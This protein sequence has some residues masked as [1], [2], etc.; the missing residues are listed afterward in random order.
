MTAAPGHR[1]TM[2]V[3]H[4]HPDDETYETGGVMARYASEGVRVV[5]VVATRG[6]VGRIA[7]H[8][9]D[10]ADNRT[11]LGALREQELR[12]ACAALAPGA[13][14]EV[15]LLGYRDSGIAGDPQND[16]PRSFWRADPNEAVVR[17]LEIMRR[18][19]PDVVVS[20]NAY[21]TDGHPDH[22][23][24]AAIAKA[25]Y[26]QAIT[27][28]PAQGP[29][30][31]YEFVAGV[32]NRR[33][34]LVRLLRRGRVREIAAVTAGYVG[35]WRPGTE[36]ERRR[37]ARASGPTTTRVDVTAY[38][39]LKA[40]ALRKHRTQVDSQLGLLLASPA[41]SKEVSPTEDFSL[42]E[43][44]VPISLPETDLFAGLRA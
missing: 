19:A 21:G 6:E 37:I 11:H 31:R 39:G 34:K 12:A 23:R 4:G 2:M 38:L 9:L 15:V 27:T 3:V 22:I 33:A 14:I 44:R 10:T 35:R 29:S 8:A 42:C 16:D 25:A 13:E 30:K 26:L 17:L 18:V 40:A 28:E 41:F 1:L 43:S 7:D 32:G 5:C 36:A 20:P 24:A